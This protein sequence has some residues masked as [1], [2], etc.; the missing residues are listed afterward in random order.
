MPIW[1]TILVAVAGSSALFGFLQY[2]ISRHD[3]KKKEKKEALEAE[4]KNEVLEAVRVLESKIDANRKES[5]ERFNAIEKRMAEERAA[6]A[7]I[8]IL[9]Y[10]DEIMHGVLHSEES[11]N[12]ILDDITQYENYCDKHPNYTNARAKLAVANINKV[13]EKCVN[14]CSFLGMR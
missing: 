12:Q 7:R 1:L 6:N 3:S 14:E 4:K 9:N 2:M 10:S 13:Y 11:F 5:D 8:R